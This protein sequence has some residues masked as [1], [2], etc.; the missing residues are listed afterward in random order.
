[1]EVNGIPHTPAALSTG[2]N[3]VFVFIYLLKLCCHPVAVVILHVYK[4]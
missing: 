3:L 1:M 4:I 2:K